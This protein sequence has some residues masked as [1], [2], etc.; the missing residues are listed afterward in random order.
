[1]SLVGENIKRIRK[2]L[3]ISQKELSIRAN[4]SQSGISDIENCTRSPSTET[5]RMIAAALG[6]T[7]AELLG[8]EKE[9]TADNSDSLRREVMFLY[10]SL[11]PER[12]Q[13]AA[14][15]LRFLADTANKPK[16]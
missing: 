13:Q 15:F 3:R 6:V 1:M 16:P 10:D 7:Q 14:D 5:I 11:P 2:S 12:R 8:E 9:A 4:V